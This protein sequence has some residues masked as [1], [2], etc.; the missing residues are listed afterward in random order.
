MKDTWRDLEDIWNSEDYRHR[1]IDSFFETGHRLPRFL[2]KRWVWQSGVVVMLFFCLLFIFQLESPQ[3]LVVQENIRY[4]LAARESD[5][6]PVLEAMARYG[7]WLDPFD[8]QVL[9]KNYLEVGAG[10]EELLAI[11]VSGK[12]ARGF[13]RQRSPIDNSP[14]FHSGIDILAEPGAPVRAT[15]SG[16]VVRVDQDPYLGRVVELDHGRGLTSLYGNLGEVLVDEGQVVEQ[17]AIIGKAGGRAPS[18]V[19]TIHFEVREKGEPVDPLS[20]M[21]PVKT[22]I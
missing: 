20:R 16:V 3:A 17:G 1:S 22:S 9:Y 19:K 15:L 6:S 5:M 14:V 18:H 8:N 13:G 21:A 2:S 4:V 12:V 7:V 11:P 10:T